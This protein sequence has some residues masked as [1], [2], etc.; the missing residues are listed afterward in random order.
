M[1]RPQGCLQAGPCMDFVKYGGRVSPSQPFFHTSHAVVCDA[2]E[3]ATKK[4][5]VPTL[6]PF[7]ENNVEIRRKE[8]RSCSR[9]PTTPFFPQ[10][11]N[12]LSHEAAINT[13]SIAV[14]IADGTE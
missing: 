7:L 11:E 12:A 3:D 2:R 4:N 9:L 14:E 5:W 13:E 6:S 10:S 1:V 8:A